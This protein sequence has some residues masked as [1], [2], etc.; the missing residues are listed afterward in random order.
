MSFPI[1]PL[2]ALLY[3][4]I[5]GSNK[6]DHKPLCHPVF[7]CKMVDLFSG[8][9]PGG[10]ISTCLGPAIRQA[11]R[12]QDIYW[13]RQNINE[14]HVEIS[15]RKLLGHT[16]YKT[17]ADSSCHSEVSSAPRAPFNVLYRLQ[18]DLCMI[19]AYL[20]YVRVQSVS[21]VRL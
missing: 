2:V 15:L 19:G 18:H 5:V 8:P 17:R 14:V 13:V 9:F 1:P 20:M 6:G 7:V 21:S 4:L 12:S 16:T 3:R 11:E 10:M